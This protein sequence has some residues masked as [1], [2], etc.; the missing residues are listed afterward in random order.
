VPYATRIHD[1]HS[2]A[3]EGEESVSVEELAVLPV[4]VE[5]SNI[6][7]AKPSMRREKE[8][9]NRQSVRHIESS[10]TFNDMQ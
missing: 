2:S 1:L 5:D 4:G 6:K 10:R 9:R 7:A 8:R 3:G